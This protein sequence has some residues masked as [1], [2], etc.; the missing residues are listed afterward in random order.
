M[1]ER[2]ELDMLARMA[3]SWDD[4]TQAMLTITIGLMMRKLKLTE[5]DMVLSVDS[6]SE[7]LDKHD[8]DRTYFVY[9]DG[10]PGMRV[11]LKQK[12]STEEP[13]ED[14]FVSLRR[15][16]ETAVDTFGQQTD[17]ELESAKIIATEAIKVYGDLAPDE[18]ADFAA[19][20][21]WHDH[22]SV[23]AALAAIRSYRK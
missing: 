10:K 22:V 6:V 23:Q 2:L 16:A 4:T 20:G 17:E 15:R 21:I 13:G 14:Y 12:H 9:P 1:S 11:A 5:I 3:E 19:Q 18:Q 8:L 7:L